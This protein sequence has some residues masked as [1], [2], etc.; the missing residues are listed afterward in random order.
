MSN[1]PKRPGGAPRVQRY[2]AVPFAEKDAA[3]ELGARWDPAK[4]KWYAP[5]G[6][7]LAPFAQW[8]PPD[9]SPADAVRGDTQR[10][11]VLPPGF[12]AYD[13]ETPPWE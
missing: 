10:E 3:K 7:D 11:P 5:Q 9:D 8:L 6:V 13:G 12:V 4:K 1:P 2:L